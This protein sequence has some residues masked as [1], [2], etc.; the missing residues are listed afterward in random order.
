MKK[1]DLWRSMSNFIQRNLHHERQKYDKLEK[2]LVKAK[3]R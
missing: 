2:T 1:S 3:E